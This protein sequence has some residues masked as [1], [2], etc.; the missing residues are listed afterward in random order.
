MLTRCADGLHANLLL[1]GRCR[2]HAAGRRPRR[3]GARQ[4]GQSDR[5]N[6][7]AAPAP[8][9]GLI[10][11]IAPVR[12]TEGKARPDDAAQRQVGEPGDSWAT[13]AGAG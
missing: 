1:A 13:A 7:G 9:T 12:S 8:Q 4:L 3:P 11:A 5:R 6:P 2:R 10:W